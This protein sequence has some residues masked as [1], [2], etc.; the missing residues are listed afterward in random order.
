M[1]RSSI[2]LTISILILA[3]LAASQCTLVGLRNDQSLFSCTDPVSKGQ[4]EFLDKTGAFAPSTGS[5]QQRERAASIAYQTAKDA[6]KP[7]VFSETLSQAVNAVSGQAADW[8]YTGTSFIGAGV[9]GLMSWRGAPHVQCILHLRTR[10]G[11]WC[12]DWVFWNPAKANTDQITAVSH[13]CGKTCKDLGWKCDVKV[14][15]HYFHYSCIPH[16]KQ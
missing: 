10:K 16:P 12:R 2:S 15:D 14:T 3:T 1:A 5:V 8:F 4:V 11:E 9:Q 13:E 6:E 7:V